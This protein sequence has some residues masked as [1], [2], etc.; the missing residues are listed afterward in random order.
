MHQIES[1]Q[2]RFPASPYLAQFQADMLAD[3]GHP[4]EAAAEYERLMRE[5]PDLSSS[6]TAWDCCEKN[7]RVGNGFRGIPPAACRLSVDER[8]AAHLSR[9][10]LHLEQYSAVK[11]S[12]SPGC[13]A[14]IRPSGPA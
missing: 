1:C 12:S 13:E 2:E 6:A 14:N 11:D 5:H 9:C 3:Q 10:M 7:A 8:A 4:D